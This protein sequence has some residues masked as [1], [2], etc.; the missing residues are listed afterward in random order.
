M[1]VWELR[2]GSSRNPE[3]D[4][5]PA[6]CIFLSALLFRLL[7]PPVLSPVLSVLAP[8]PFLSTVQGL[9][10]KIA[11]N[12]PCKSPVFLF[13]TAGL[14]PCGETP[15]QAIGC[16][17]NR[18]PGAAAKSAVLTGISVRMG[19]SCACPKA[20]E[21]GQILKPKIVL[22]PRARRPRARRGAND[23][24]LTRPPS[25][26]RTD[27]CRQT[28]ADSRSRTRANSRGRSASDRPGSAPHRRA[29]AG[30][31]AR[32]REIAD[33]GWQGKP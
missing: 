17:R 13:G 27:T 25:A 18:L 11:P 4:P 15:K 3:K 12:S 6:A 21:S 20:V 10:L 1:G 7:F 8:V 33:R 29:I 5:V 24:A 9:T 14:H 22:F 32:S 30:R 2:P 23:T 19:L 28:C 16:G 26:P 31:R